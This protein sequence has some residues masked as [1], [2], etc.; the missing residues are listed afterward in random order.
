MDNTEGGDGLRSG[1][2]K[3]RRGVIKWDR[4]TEFVYKYKLSRM[5]ADLR[6]R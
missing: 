1:Q 4:V 5:S 2:R 6:V 3:E